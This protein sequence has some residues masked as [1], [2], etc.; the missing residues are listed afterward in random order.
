MKHTHAKESLSAQIALH[1]GVES[2]RCYQCGKCSAGCPMATDMEYTPSMTMRMLQIE[3]DETDRQLLESEGI[4]MC[5]TCEMC[6]S[7]CP[8]SVRYPQS[9]GSPERNCTGKKS[10]ES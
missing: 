6:I 3:E 8:M 10:S 2:A 4:W 5:L 7:R 9:Y 1:T